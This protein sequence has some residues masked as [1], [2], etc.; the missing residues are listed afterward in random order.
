MD[1]NLAYRI[2]F[3]PLIS[4]DKT[5]FGNK[6]FVKKVLSLVFPSIL[7]LI[8]GIIWVFVLMFV[9]ALFGIAYHSVGQYIS[10]TTIIWALFLIVIPSIRKYKKMNVL[11][12]FILICVFLLAI[13][14]FMFR[15]T[16]I[17]GSIKEAN[18]TNGQNIIINLIYPKNALRRGDVAFYRIN[19]IERVGL[20]K[21]V[22]ANQFIINEKAIPYK[23]V[24]G[25]VV[26]VFK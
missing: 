3:L 9:L 11:Y 8:W 15:F 5:L 1:N 6:T 24:D 26:F 12:A 21:S 23:D 20:I 10:L 25:K 19:E 2:I 4:I 22:T 14:M 7:L 18:I 13:Q 16:T 17:S